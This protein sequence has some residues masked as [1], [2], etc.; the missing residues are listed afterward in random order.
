[1]YY[2]PNRNLLL[3]H[4]DSNT[5]LLWKRVPLHHRWNDYC[6]LPHFN[7]F[8]S[9]RLLVRIKHSNSVSRRNVLTLVWS[10]SSFSLYLNSS[11]FL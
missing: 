4:Y 5:S 1:M 9:A 2:L 8:V 7:Q 10:Y 3:K 11:R 6:T